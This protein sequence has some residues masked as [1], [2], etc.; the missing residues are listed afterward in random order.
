MVKVFYHNDPD[1]WCSAYWVR[2]HL[3]NE[4]ISFT[5]SDF[6]E[7]NYDKEF[8]WEI[9]TSG[10]QV[11]M[12]DFSLN[13]PMNMALLARDYDFTWIDHHASAI[14]KMSIV[15]RDYKLKGV[16]YDGISGCMLTWIYLISGKHFYTDE[17]IQSAPLFTQYIHLWDTWQWKNEDYS[18][19]CDIES[20]I[21]RIVASNN[22]SNPLSIWWN[23]I[24]D[25]ECAT[26]NIE[27]LVEEGRAMIAFRDGYGKI[28]CDF[29][30]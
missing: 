6:I 28:C 19:Q 10:E 29:N 22:A 1:G 17:H 26:R 12:V 14:E 13:D 4:G 16:R 8:P 30:W 11:F 2:K 23:A 9:L 21:T 7:M 5:E 24:D 3:E 18:K 15:Y 27:L 20:F 25:V